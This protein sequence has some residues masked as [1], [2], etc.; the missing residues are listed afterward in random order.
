M[1]YLVT[2][3]VEVDT[4]ETKAEWEA[5]EKIVYTNNYTVNVQLM[6]EHDTLVQQLNENHKYTAPYKYED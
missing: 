3:T 1:K 2:Y 5:F 4:D 6:D